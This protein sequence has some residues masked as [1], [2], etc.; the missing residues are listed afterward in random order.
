M[1]GTLVRGE[2]V[3]HH[4]ATLGYHA[5][6]GGVD[7]VGVAGPAD[8]EERRVHV[9]RS[10]FVADSVQDAHTGL[11]RLELVDCGAG[12]DLDAAPPESVVERDRDVDIGSRHDP[13]RVLDERHFAAEVRQDRRELAARVG[14]PALTPTRSCRP[15]P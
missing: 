6:S 7:V 13:G 5:G 10:G 8:G 1:W 9:D 15:R 3:D 2:R 12:D 11:E 14:R 4:V